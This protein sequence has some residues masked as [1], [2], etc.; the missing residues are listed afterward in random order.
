MNDFLEDGSI[1]E[2]EYKGQKLK[3]QDPYGFVVI[4]GVDGQYTTWAEAYK[5]ID[6]AIEKSALAKKATKAAAPTKSN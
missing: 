2:T 5:A 1:R 6:A 4:E 3:M